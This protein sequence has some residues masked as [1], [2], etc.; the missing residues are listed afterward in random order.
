MEAFF[1]EIDE[2]GFKAVMLLIWRF[3][4]LWPSAFA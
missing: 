2:F 3:A 4:Y 1:W